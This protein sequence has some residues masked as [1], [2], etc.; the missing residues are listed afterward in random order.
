MRFGELIE[1][2]EALGGGE[3][4]REVGLFGAACGAGFREAVA[5]LAVYGLAAVTERFGALSPRA[6]VLHLFK[7]DF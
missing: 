4:R 3:G 1:A 6:K 2:E 5:M 7:D